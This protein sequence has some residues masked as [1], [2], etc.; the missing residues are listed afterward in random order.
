MEEPG[1]GAR[2]PAA[3]GPRLRAGG[4]SQSSAAASLAWLVAALAASA[5][6]AGC[7]VRAGV[8][9]AS[10]HSG[11]AERKE[12]EEK[13]RENSEVHIK[14]G[15]VSSTGVWRDQLKMCKESSGE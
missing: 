1:G 6:A 4:C 12:K 10:V 7:R 3:Q 13:Y 5:G 2:P 8:G 14:E 11:G 15:L 9:P